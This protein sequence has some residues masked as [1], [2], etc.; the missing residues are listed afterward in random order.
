[1]IDIN[2]KYKTEDGRP[3]RILCTNRNNKKCV[4][5]LV[6]DKNN[7]QDIIS[8]TADGKADSTN[9]HPLNLI[10]ITPYDQLKVDDKIMVSDDG[11]IWSSRH[12]AEV[13]NGVV[14]TFDNGKT[15]WSTK[16]N[17][18]VLISWKYVRDQDGIDL[19]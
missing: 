2:K 3:A 13:R 7:Y 6:T 18:G 1:M 5:A 12:F 14:Y 17:G 11:H 8:Y 9:S 10:E 16:N 19:I 15:S 4:V